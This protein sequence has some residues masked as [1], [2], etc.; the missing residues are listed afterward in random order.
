[1]TVWSLSHHILAQ[2]LPLT[3]AKKPQTP[4][5]KGKDG[6]S[7]HLKLDIPAKLQVS[8]GW[9]VVYTT[10]IILALARMSK[11]QSLPF[12]ESVQINIAESKVESTQLPECN[13]FMG[14]GPCQ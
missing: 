1:M 11:Q 13:T 14:A 8:A 3:L 9:A 5:F 7:P 10:K 6:P 12:M 4:R 2:Q